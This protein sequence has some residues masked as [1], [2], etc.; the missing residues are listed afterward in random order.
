[1]QYNKKTKCYC[2]L[3][4]RTGRWNRAFV[5]PVRS[6]KS[7]FLP[8]NRLRKNHNMAF[9]CNPPMDTLRV[10]RLRPIYQM[11]KRK[12]PLSWCL[13]FCLWATKKVFSAVLCMTSNSHISIKPH[14]NND[15]SVELNLL[16]GIIID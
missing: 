9:S 6:F 1:V 16:R 5:P 12:T 3:G 2:Y 13:S 10:P 8:S 14:S 7:G 4:T 15:L 11:P